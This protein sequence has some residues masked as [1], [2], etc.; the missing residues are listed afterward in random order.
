MIALF[1]EAKSNRLSLI[2]GFVIAALLA[3]G[4]FWL[5]GNAGFNLWDEG[6]LWHNI[7][8][9]FEGD[10]PIRDFRSYDPGRF[11]WGALWFHL[12]GPGIMV[13]RIAML[14]LQ[15]VGLGFGLLAMRR[16][17]ASKW[18]M[19]L[20]TILL[21]LWMYPRHKIVIHTLVL[22]ALYIAVRLIEKP[23]LLR[24]FGAGVL[25]GIT[26]CFARDFAV[27][28]LLGYIGLIGYIGFHKQLKE[29][30][31]K[32]AV[33][34]SGIFVGY[35][36]ILIMLLFI[37]GFFTAFLDSIV[38]VFGPYAPIKTLPIPWPW[39]IAINSASLAEKLL[40]I[41]YLLLWGF[42]LVS[43]LKFLFSKKNLSL[44]NPLWVACVFIGVPMLH[45]INGRADF[46]HFIEGG[47]PL[48]IGV[49]AVMVL[50]YR[51]KRF[52]MA[53]V[54]T[55]CLI[56]LL[57]LVL[58]LSPDTSMA[59]SMIKMHMGERDRIVAYKIGSD[60]LWLDR[61]Q[62]Q[63]I[64]SIKQFITPRLKTDQNILIAPFEPGF[65]PI[66]GR[67]SP[68]W[69]AFPIHNASVKEQLQ[70]IDDLEQKNTAWAIVSDAPLDGIEER[71]F[72][73]THPLLWQY[74]IKNYRRITVPD[75]PL[76]YY[77]LQKTP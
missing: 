12:L 39:K 18:Q 23:N 52:V 58:A 26:A 72:S 30:G 29:M 32:Y 15:I 10:T 5:Q 28:F 62:A 76:D 34:L 38:R 35:L 67:P 71:R 75:T 65:Y 48:L 13:Q 36:P 50:A 33:F 27:Y 59:E 11:Y 63:Y 22:L 17:I 16:L 3:V 55:L 8:R 68:I 46:S 37:P 1:P 64:E 6:Y 60:D 49:I 41:S 61:G 73:K 70:S 42:Y 66:I 53:G 14:L 57:R 45:H 31:R 20:I 24:H 44:S 9:T 19:A 43:A 4:W 21:L 25:T 69:D 2:W 40:G 77:Y 54:T 47:L 56:I 51:Q 74:L 7:Q